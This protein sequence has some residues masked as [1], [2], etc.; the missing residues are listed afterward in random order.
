MD[1]DDVHVDEPSDLLAT[2]EIKS[3][4]EAGPVKSAFAV[5]TDDY[6]VDDD[7]NIVTGVI[8]SSKGQ[9]LEKRLEVTPRDEY[10]TFV[11]NQSAFGDKS[12]G[13]DDCPVADVPSKDL[14]TDIRFSW[15]FKVDLIIKNFPII[16]EAKD[17]GCFNLNVAT[18]KEEMDKSDKK[19]PDEDQQVSAPTHNNFQP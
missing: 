1:A 10:V 6:D 7:N 9:E 15:G 2:A 8:S 16:A 13:Y 18:I 19:L 11:F 12:I 4:A 5:H 17:C 3:E 14:Y